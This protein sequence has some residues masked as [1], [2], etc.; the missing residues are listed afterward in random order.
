MA[1]FSQN[2]L[3]SQTQSVGP[4]WLFWV[5]YWVSHISGTPWVPGESGQLVTL[6]E[7]GNSEQ[8]RWRRLVPKLGSGQSTKGPGWEWTGDANLL[9]TCDHHSSGLWAQCDSSP[10]SKMGFWVLNDQVPRGNCKRA[11]RGENALT[12]TL[13]LQQENWGQ[14]RQRSHL[15][16]PAVSSQLYLKITTWK[17][18][19]GHTWDSYRTGKTKLLLL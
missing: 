3:F 17:W 9:C 16:G 1:F 19:V 11:R 12:R 6:A 4:G 5:S 10:T 13:G 7:Q 18:V 15:E 8:L 2:S 14:G